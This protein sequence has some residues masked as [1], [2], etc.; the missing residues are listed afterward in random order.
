MPLEGQQ[1]DHYRLVRLI[2]SGGM[3]EVYLAEDTCINRQLAIKIVR[4]EADPYPD[5]HATKEATRLSQREMKAITTLDF[6]EVKR[7]H[8]KDSNV[9]SIF[10]RRS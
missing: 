10:G 7:C 6:L 5:A 8:W 3:G 9:E 1:L 2:G 4:T